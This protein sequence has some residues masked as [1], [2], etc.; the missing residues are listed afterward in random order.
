MKFNNS[1]VVSTEQVQF[2]AKNKSRKLLTADS[3]N[4]Q[5]ASNM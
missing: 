3:E 5:P 4:N 2:N 1:K